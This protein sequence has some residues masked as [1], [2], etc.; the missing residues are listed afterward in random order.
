VWGSKICLVYS[1]RNNVISIKKKIHI[2]SGRGITKCNVV[3]ERTEVCIIYEEKAAN[4]FYF[5][6]KEKLG[7][8]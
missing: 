3:L 5:K 1:G 7:D 4:I 6:E 2:T 8:E